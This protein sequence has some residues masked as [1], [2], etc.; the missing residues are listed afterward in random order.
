MIDGAGTVLGEREADIVGTTG[1]LV[2]NL[3]SPDPSDLAR[4]GSVLGRGLSGLE[5]ATD[6]S[7]AGRCGCQCE[8]GA[9][10]STMFRGG[11]TTSEIR[12]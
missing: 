12:G 7:A 3:L 11:C 6:L 4:G 5:S 8:G 2:L 10:R 9:F 1:Y